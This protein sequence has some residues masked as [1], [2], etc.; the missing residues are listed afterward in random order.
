MQKDCPLQVN[1]KCQLFQTE[2]GERPFSLCSLLQQAY[3][4]GRQAGYKEAEAMD[5]SEG[6]GIGGFHDY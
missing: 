1:G 3:E 2:C 5:L 4:L 6:S